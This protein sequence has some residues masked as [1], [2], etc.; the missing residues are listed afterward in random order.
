[1]NDPVLTAEQRAAL[2]ESGGLPVRVIDR[3]ASKKHILMD[4]KVYELLLAAI[5]DRDPATLDFLRSAGSF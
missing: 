5:G 2:H 1:M 3:A 4:V